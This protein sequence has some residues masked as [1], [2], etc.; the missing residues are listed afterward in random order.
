MHDCREVLRL[1]KITGPNPKTNSGENY[2]NGK[3]KFDS[4]IYGSDRDSNP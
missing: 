2:T 3:T 1:K 4:S